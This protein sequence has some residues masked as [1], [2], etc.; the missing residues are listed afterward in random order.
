MG[1]VTPLL[2]VGAAERRR[3]RRRGKEEQEEERMGG[4]IALCVLNGMIN[5]R[6]LQM[7][8]SLLRTSRDTTG[9]PLVIHTHTHTAHK[10]FYTLQTHTHTSHTPV[11]ADIIINKGGTMGSGATI[12]NT[13]RAGSVHSS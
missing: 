10:G 4:W 2:N 11:T 1:A 3:K 5:E 6:R 12:A 13:T 9:S 7:V 8:L